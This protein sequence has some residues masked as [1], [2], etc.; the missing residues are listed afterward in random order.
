MTTDRTIK[1]LAEGLMKAVVRMGVVR[2]GF[3]NDYTVA[4]R[5]MREEL[6]AFLFDTKY[7]DERELV[8]TGGHNLAMASVVAE[9]G[10]RILAERL[11]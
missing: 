3:D 5:V 4:V 10:R 11:N 6:K 7:T 8:K 2:K 9:C 1:N